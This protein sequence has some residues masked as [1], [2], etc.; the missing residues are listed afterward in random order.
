VAKLSISKAWDETRGIIGRHG[1]LL[2]TVALALLVL[3]GVISELVSP[4]AQQGQLPPLG[5][6]MIV[7]AIAV[8]IGLVGQLAII[9]LAMGSGASVGEAIRHGLRRAPSYI[10]A[11]LIWA[12][13][14]GL[15]IYALMKGIRP[16]DPSPAAGL[17]LLVLLPVMIFFVI[18]MI[19]TAPVAAAE[20][21][22]PIEIIKR[23]WQL[24]AGSWWRLFG[25]FAVLVVAALV[26]LAAVG[27]VVGSMT[28]LAFGELEPMSVGALALA[29]V[30]QLAGAA[31]TVVFV[32]MLARIYVQLAGDRSAEASVPTSGD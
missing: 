25:F 5:A 14:F 6:W 2:V 3:P 20:E 8:L 9:W 10:A 7:A 26:V 21:I 4:E 27:A 11:T 30:N 31:L 23:S 12:L 28:R 17:G 32:V 29:V 16:E 18:R 13:P 22:G 15:A 1:G 19:L 24:T